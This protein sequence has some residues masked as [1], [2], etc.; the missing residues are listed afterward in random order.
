MARYTVGT[1]INISEESYREEA[2]LSHENKKEFFSHKCEELLLYGIDINGHVIK[3][4]ERNFK[5]VR[6]SSIIHR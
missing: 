4:Y 6:K 1:L 2:L 5:Y 3:N